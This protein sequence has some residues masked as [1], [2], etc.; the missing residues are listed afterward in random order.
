M[1]SHGFYL[2]ALNDGVIVLPRFVYYT[3]KGFDNRDQS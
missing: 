2:V 1:I 3:T